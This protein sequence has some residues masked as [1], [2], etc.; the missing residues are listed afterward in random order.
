MKYF[1]ILY[2]ILCIS[3]NAIGQISYEQA[4]AIAKEYF[5]NI[6]KV[7]MEY[8]RII[9]D[10]DKENYLLA[11]QANTRKQHHHYYYILNICSVGCIPIS[12]GI[13]KCNLLDTDG[14]SVGFCSTLAISKSDGTIYD[15]NSSSFKDFNYMIKS[16]DIH[17]DNELIFNHYLTFIIRE[18]DLH[19]DAPTIRNV[20][21][22]RNELTS[23]LIDHLSIADKK[24]IRRY[25]ESFIKLYVDKWMSEYIL[26][27]YDK[28][29]GKTTTMDGEHY[30]IRNTYLAIMIN[31][32]CLMETSIIIAKDGTI[33]DDQS[34]EIFCPTEISIDNPLTNEP[35]YIELPYIR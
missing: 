34:N 4:E 24:G 15:L 9:R 1:I 29:L 14:P 31:H 2:T 22:L 16:I 3:N 13:Y 21:H 26:I 8:G 10:I 27:R 5:M 19:Q 6:N 20:Y 35:Q 25:N 11:F 28:P 30:I 7:D 18:L 32:P 33:E 17:I 23:I 12:Q